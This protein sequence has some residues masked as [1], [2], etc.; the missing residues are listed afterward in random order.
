M[1]DAET[2]R[3]YDDMA[4]T[5]QK[6]FSD[7]AADAT[8]LAF[9]AAMPEGGRVL[10]F[11]CGPGRSAMHMARAGLRVDAT[12]GSATMVGLAA[13]H[14]GVTAWQASFDALD[15]VAQYDGVWANFSLLHADRADVPAH[16]TA[17]RRALRARGLLHIGVKE[18]TGEARD[19]LGRRYTYFTL[20][21]MEAMLRAAGFSPGPATRGEG[22]GLDGSVASFFTLS[23][24]S[25]A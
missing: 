3:V 20:P 10:D 13:Q 5:Y 19:S 9:I 12:D 7:K 16:L 24:V 23:A 4:L 25:D 1:T 18:G 15:A 17:I 11:G 2:L 14:P 22:P 6:V 21:E 8:L